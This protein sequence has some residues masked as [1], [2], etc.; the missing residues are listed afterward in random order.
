MET[1]YQEEFEFTMNDEDE[2]IDWAQNNMNWDEV[3]QQAV[4]VS[5]GEIDW[6][7]G[8]VNGE[9]EVIEK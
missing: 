2:L 3:K 5:D 1:V 7:D 6:Q 9:K 8:W 4:K